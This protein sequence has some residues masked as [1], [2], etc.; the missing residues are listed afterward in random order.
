MVDG[1]RIFFQ[2]MPEDISDT[3][4]ATYT[5]YP[6]IG[7][8][9]PLKAYEASQSR[10]I[11][12]TLSFFTMPVEAEFAPDP[13]II[14]TWMDKLRS[15]TYP[16]YSQGGVK[17]PHTFIINI[18]GFIAMEAVMTQYTLSYPFKVWTPGMMLPYGSTINLTM[19]EVRDIPLS[20]EEVTAGA[21]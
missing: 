17:P 1:S 10:I 16:D 3:K 2:F 11:T 9:I 6:I 14:K 7:R 18:G 5:D 21:Q 19:A 12:L 20:T 4:Q 13:F 8:S 15:F